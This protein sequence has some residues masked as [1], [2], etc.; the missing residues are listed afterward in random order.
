M[1]RPPDPSMYRITGHFC[2]VVYPFGTNTWKAGFTWQPVEDSLDRA[3]PEV[4]PARYSYRLRC[5]LDGPARLRRLAV[6]SDVQMA[7]LALA[8]A[9]GTLHPA[10][11]REPGFEP[12]FDGWRACYGAG[13]LWS[14]RGTDLSGYFPDLIS[15]LHD[16]L[17]RIV[18]EDTARDV[19]HG[20]GRRHFRWKYHPYMPVEFSGA[21]FRFGHSL[22]REDYQMRDDQL[23]V[24][25]IRQSPDDPRQPNRRVRADRGRRRRY[26]ERQD[27]RA[28]ATDH[29]Q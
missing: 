28:R 10:G 9:S 27:L 18:G 12:K 19:V 4:G 23:N 2:A 1:P 26:P 22:V 17:P 21:A 11:V 29:D 20:E 16:L 3:F 24:P 8:R 6:L 14:R 7:P 15:V 5:E 25:I 13:R